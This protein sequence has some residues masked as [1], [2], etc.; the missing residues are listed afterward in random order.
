MNDRHCREIGGI[1]SVPRIAILLRP[2]FYPVKVYWISNL[3]I[4]VRLKVV[5]KKSMGTTVEV[6]KSS[7][8][9][10]NLK[11]PRASIVANGGLR[12]DPAIVYPS[13]PTSGSSVPEVYPFVL[14]SRNNAR[15]FR[16]QSCCTTSVNSS[17][18][19]SI[20]SSSSSVVVVVVVVTVIVVVV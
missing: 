11:I 7:S 14:R 8:R 15:I 2:E 5:A 12:E 17:S 18:S 9:A 16:S 13:N 4:E 20:S 6:S 10:L 1:K 3:R 19:I